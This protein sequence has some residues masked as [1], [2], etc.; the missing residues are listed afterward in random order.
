MTKKSKI[1]ILTPVNVVGFILI[2]M[3]G[4][5]DTVGVN[6]FLYESSCFM[7]GRGAILGNW[8]FIG[9]IKAFLSVGIIIISFILGSYISTL[10]TKKLGL[11]GGLCFTGVLIIIT[12]LTINRNDILIATIIIPMAMGGQNA[13]TSLTPI[14]RTTHLT[15]P[16]TDIGI[17]LA[18]GNWNI[19]IFWILRWIGF[20]IGSVIGYSLVHMVENNLINIS[21]TLILPAIIIILTGLIQRLLFNIPLTSKVD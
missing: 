18:Q 2:M 11:T 1:E 4:W 14:N 9:N 19:A 15:G 8:A 13:A 20:P 6:L 5:I 3:A 21:T 7:S 16:A 10:L 12:A 17:N